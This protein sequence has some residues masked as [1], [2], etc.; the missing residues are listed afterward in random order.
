MTDEARGWDHRPTVAF[1][2]STGISSHW[3]EI[4]DIVQKIYARIKALA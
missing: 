3:E 2:F 1:F 4:I